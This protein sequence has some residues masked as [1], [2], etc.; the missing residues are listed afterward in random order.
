MYDLCA[1]FLLFSSKISCIFL[2]LMLLCFLLF[3]PVMPAMHR[4]QSNDA[5]I[6]Q[7]KKSNDVAL[8]SL[9]KQSNYAERIATRVVMSR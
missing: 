1:R 5:T 9:K 3:R 4:K 7:T 6:T 2:R 8:S